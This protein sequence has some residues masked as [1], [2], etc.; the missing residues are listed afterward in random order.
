MLKKF[1]SIEFFVHFISAPVV[2]ILGL[3]GN[4]M[5]LIVLYRKNLIKFG[6]IDVYKYLFIVDSTYLLTIL[7]FYFKNFGIDITILSSVACKSFFYFSYS[8]QPI[9]ALLHIYILVERYLAVKYPIESNLLCKRKTQKV[10]LTS[11]FV[12]NFVFYLPIPFSY[13]V[14]AEDSSNKTYICHFK[15]REAQDV[16]S[17]LVFISK[18]LV[19]LILILIF[20]ILLSRAISNSNKRMSIYYNRRE[21]KIFKKDVRLSIITIVLNLIYIS[22]YFP[23]IFVVFRKGIFGSNFWFVLTLNLFYLSFAFNFYLFVF[24][25]RLFRKEFLLVFNNK[26]IIE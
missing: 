10:Y 12:L 19:P 16:I 15:N 7:N 18:L 23:V 2:L 25:N 26:N 13:D 17:I 3:F 11:V 14:I 4:T 1:N 8:F 6:P 24:T 21:R 5:G 20:S 9:S 22:L